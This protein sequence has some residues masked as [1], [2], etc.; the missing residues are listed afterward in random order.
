VK[1]FFEGKVQKMIISIDHGYGMIKTPNFM[2]KT[3]IAKYDNEPYTNQNVVQYNNKYYVCGSGR[4]SLVRDKT[5]DES[6]YI[7]TLMAIAKELEIREAGTRE[8]ITLACGLPL[9]SFGR[10][11]KKFTDYLKQSSF[12][13][14]KFAFEGKKY[15]INIENVTMFPQGYSAIIDCIKPLKQEASVILCDVGSWTVDVM[16][17]DSGVPNAETCRSLELGIIRMTDEILEQ[18]R[19]NTGLSIS[20]NQVEQ[21]LAKK[22]CSI[23]E[24][25]KAIIIEQG[26]AYV[27]K[28]IRTLLESGFDISAIPIL[29]IGGGSVLVRKNIDENKVCKLKLDEDVQSKLDDISNDICANSKGYEKI[30]RTQI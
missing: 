22:P 25:A 7:L 15:R 11:K 19:R 27:D 6:Y 8:N 16:R 4:Q 18:V 23:N 28:L 3:G 2:F 14:V 17:L 30:A 10:E 13:P 24:S 12:Q 26:K 9:T 5:A 1:K 21:V 20:Q 29:F